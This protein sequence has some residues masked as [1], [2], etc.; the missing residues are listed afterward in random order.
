MTW[1]YLIVGAGFAGAVLAERL[2]SQRGA[3]CLVV[4]RRNHI[5]G[6]AYDRF[7]SAGVL[8]HPYGP[9]YFRTNSQRIVDYLS[10]F[11]EWRA[12]EY[13]VLSWTKG[14]FWQF[15]INLNTFE[16]FIG[17][18]S[19]SEEMERTLAEW[20]IPITNPQN[21]EEVILSQ[22]GRPLYELR[23]PPDATIVA[24]I[25]EGHVVIPQPE[26]VITDGDEVLALTVPEAESALRSA[27]LGEGDAP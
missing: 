6:N 20:R 9:H 17:R 21:S 2:A 15:P 18:P 16:Q 26:T 8:I 23:L 10:Q 7:D 3:T 1:D 14:A 22:V 12:V 13:R 11:T 4:D 5:G 27:V 19:T 25:R 24:I